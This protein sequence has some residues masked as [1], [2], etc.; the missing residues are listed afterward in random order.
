MNWIKEKVLI[1]LVILNQFMQ[2]LSFLFLKNS[3][4]ILKY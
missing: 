4:K 2:I 3:L 1:M